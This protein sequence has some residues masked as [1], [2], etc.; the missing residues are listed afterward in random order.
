MYFRQPHGCSYKLDV[1]G[2]DFSPFYSSTESEMISLDA[3]L[4]M[5]GIP[6]LDL[7][8][9]VIEVLHSSPNRT[10]RLQRVRR[11]PL[12]NKTSG[13]RTNAQSR[14]QIPKECLEL[15]SVDC[16][17]S[18]RKSSRLRPTVCIFEDPQSCVV[19]VVWQDLPRQFTYV[20]TK[21]QLAA[22]L[23]K[24]NSTRDEWYHLLCLFN[25]SKVQLFKLR[26]SDVEKNN[27]KEHQKKEVRPNQSR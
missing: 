1:Q 19:L 23:T 22:I 25:I 20:D 21:D 12:L 7:W 26:A 27:R 15:S 4:R 8:D 11:D 16:I 24:G 10:Q 2:A 13:K 17:S 6:A 5:D 9:L 18:N 14:T 3:D